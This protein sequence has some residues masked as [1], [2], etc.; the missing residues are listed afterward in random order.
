MGARPLNTQIIGEA[1]EAIYPPRYATAE[2]IFP[3]PEI[4]A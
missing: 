4:D 2:P 1:I 3:I